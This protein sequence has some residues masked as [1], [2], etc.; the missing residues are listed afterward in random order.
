VVN[1]ANPYPLDTNAITFTGLPAGCDVVV[2]S[3]GTSNVLHQVDS[4]SGTSVQYIYSGAQTVDVGFIKPGY[5]PQYIR[6]L[7][8]GTSDVSLPV[9]L[10]IDRNYS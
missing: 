5:V 8:L 9:S 2:L 1:A 7:A 4:F 3:A 6:N 10:T